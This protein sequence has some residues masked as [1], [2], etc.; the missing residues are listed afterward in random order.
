VSAHQGDGTLTHVSEARQETPPNFDPSRQTIGRR[1]GIQARGLLPKSAIIIAWLLEIVV[2][3]LLEPS[4]FLTGSSFKQLAS[5]QASLV[6]LCLAVVP[7]LAVGEIDLSVAS[8]MALS[9]TTFGQLNGVDHW[10]FW[11]AVVV[12]LLAAVLTGV[13]SGATTVYLRVRGIIVTL[14][15]GTFVGGMSLLI[16]HSLTVGG[17]SPGLGDVVTHPLVGI[18]AAFFMALFVAV[19]LWYLLRHTPT[20]RSMLFLGFNRE[21]ARLSGINEGRLRFGSFVLGSLIAG[22]AG[23]VAI[24]IAGGADPTSFQPLLLPAFAATFLGQLTFTPGRVNPLGN[25]VA[26]YFLATGIFGIELL[27]VGTWINDAFYG[28]ALVVI[29]AL[30]GVV[31]KVGITSGRQGSKA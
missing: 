12:A 30:S 19:C 21:V 5:S 24:G 25:V 16:S 15:M 1:K 26:L 23:I 13:I 31:E 14:G 22:V 7:T 27:G 28:G 18:S 17:I 20:G 4:S 2:F 6:I 8:V 29:V 10:G 9:A 3:G 11:P